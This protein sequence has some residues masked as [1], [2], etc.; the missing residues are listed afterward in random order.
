MKFSAIYHQLVLCWDVCFVFWSDISFSHLVKKSDIINKVSGNQK[1]KEMMMIGTNLCVWFNGRG[2][3]GVTP[4]L[5]VGAAILRAYSAI[6]DSRSFGVGRPTARTR[7]FLDR[8]FELVVVFDF[9]A[10]IIIVGE[11]PTSTASGAFDF[12]I[13]L[14]LATNQYDAMM[15]TA[16]IISRR[17]R[18]RLTSATPCADDGGAP[19]QTTIR[20]LRWTNR[21]R[22]TQSCC[23]VVECAAATGSSCPHSGII[24]IA[25]ELGYLP[26]TFCNRHNYSFATH[27][28]HTHASCI[29]AA[30]AAAAAIG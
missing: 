10:A 26:F 22:L 21:L 18:N 16:R 12:R 11:Q 8:L 23:T 14:K 7:T 6:F 24:A 28:L 30:F 13:G 15:P 25:S 5:A 9:A 19:L 29:V 3:P 20:P 4:P 27:R 17:L 2:R 1:S